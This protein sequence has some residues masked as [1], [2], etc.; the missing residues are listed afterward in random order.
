MRLIYIMTQKFSLQGYKAKEYGHIPFKKH[1]NNKYFRI[2]A[3]KATRHYNTKTKSFTSVKTIWTH[4][5]L[6]I[7]KIYH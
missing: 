5:Y 7:M 2:Q 3:K 4:K 6:R 1:N